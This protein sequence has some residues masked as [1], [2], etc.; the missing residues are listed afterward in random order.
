MLRS[1]VR[2]LLAVLAAAALSTVATLAAA[3]P[4]AHAAAS[5]VLL[6]KGTGSVYTDFE[7]VNLGIIPGNGTKSFS[8]KVVNTGATNQQFLVVTELVTSGTGYSATL[9]SGY[10]AVQSPFVTAPIRPGGSAVLTLKIAVNAGEP[11][12][13]YIAGVQLRDPVTEDVLDDAFADANA[14]YQTGNTQHDL[15]LK[16]GSQPFVGGSEPQFETASTIRVGNTATFLLRLKNNG[17]TPATMTVQGSP[18]IFCDP[19]SFVVT[20]KQ[21]FANVT[22]AVAAGTYS[23]GSL[24]PGAKKELKVTIKLVSEAGCVSPA[25]YFFFQAT[26]P[27]GSIG[28][29]AH[30]V[31]AA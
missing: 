19:S 10:K 3:P 30:V 11:P 17:S 2:R 9:F 29:A 21:G 28:S 31:F 22:A 4:P 18:P 8:F 1:P 14:T 12:G 23:T 26:G 20:V 27:D 16:T 15:F 24:N 6:M 7:G 5:G 25:D 13:E